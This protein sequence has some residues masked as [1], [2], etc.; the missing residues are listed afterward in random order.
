[1]SIK[2]SL[3]LFF[4][5]IIKYK[6][7]IFTS[8]YSDIISKYKQDNFG[9][10]WSVILPI[11]PMSLYLLLASI[12]AFKKS[13]DMPYIFYITIG[14]MIWLL[15]SEIIVTT[16]K[17]L[18]K[19]KKI[20]LK[21]NF[22]FSVVYISS[23]GEL[24]VNMFIR[25]IFVIIIMITFSIHIDILNLFLTIFAL[26]PIIIFAFSFGIILSISDIYIP[27]TKRLVD[28]FLRYGLF[29]SSVIFPFPKD[30]ILGFLN[31]FN[32]FNTFV[33]SVRSVLYFGTIYNYI[34]YTVFSIISIILFTIAI[35]IMLKIEFKVRSGL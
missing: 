6:N 17:S 26:T 31:Q 16:M 35:F 32:I 23:I 11:V 33:E 1:L 4:N 30:G 3:Q 25:L 12:K 9:L 2:K 13:E 29:L 20:L 15:M 24:L 34:G 18:R 7:Y 22:P 21:S 5:E 14:M 19:N 27:D 10:L 8:I 28:M